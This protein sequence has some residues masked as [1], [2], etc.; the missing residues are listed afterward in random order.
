MLRFLSTLHPG[1]QT[2]WSFVR[3]LVLFCIVKC[4]HAAAKPALL[5]IN[6]CPEKPTAWWLAK[7]SCIADQQKQTRSYS[8]DL[9]PA[10][11]HAGFFVV[12]GLHF[13][14]NKQAIMV[15]CRQQIHRSNIM[16]SWELYKAFS[17][18][19]AVAEMAIKWRHYSPAALIADFCL[20]RNSNLHSSR[21]AEDEV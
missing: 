18:A 12:S 7:D 15:L 21:S 16:N 5:V 10:H 14:H 19:H 4:W 6:V 9:L 3:S 11:F 20:H 8:V 2:C 13:F 1:L 17:L